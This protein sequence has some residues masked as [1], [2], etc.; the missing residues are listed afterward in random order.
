MPRARSASRSRPD[1]PLTGVRVP[2]IRRL[3][4]PALRERYGEGRTGASF[5]ERLTDDDLAR[6]N[7][8]LPWRCFT[9][10]RDGRPFGGAAW[11]GKRVVPEVI[12]DRRIA[13]L[14]ERFDLSNK[15][16][17]EIGCF[18]GI[19]TIALCQLADRVTAIDARV[20]NVVKTVVRCAFFDQRPRVFVHDVEGEESDD[21][22][23]RSDVCHHVGVLYHLEDPITHLRHLARWISRGLMLDTHYAREEDATDEYQV[24]G[25]RFR[26]RRYK[27]LGRGDVFSGMR[28]ASKWIRLDDI[29][30]VLREG[31]FDRFEI[32]ETRE[33]RNG[34]RAL[35]FAERLLA[36]EGK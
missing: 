3:Q 14:H 11:R 35:L 4:R 20:E 13:L 17:L 2:S 29:E 15:H 36:V 28:P 12:P 21:D 23:M 19:H 25:E 27:E 22:L 31:G 33:E 26:F 24:D 18:E 10:D 1:R 16:V 8:L 7:E 6:L 34:P 5:V 32:V 30:G 9:V